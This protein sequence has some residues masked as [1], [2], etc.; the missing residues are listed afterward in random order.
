MKLLEILGQSTDMLKRFISN[1]GSF[2]K[3]DLISK[4]GF[5]GSRINSSLK[6]DI[7]Y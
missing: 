7:L 5:I 2:S 3:C 6:R 1:C 4:C